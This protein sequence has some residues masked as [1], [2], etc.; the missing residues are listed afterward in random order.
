MDFIGGYSLGNNGAYACDRRTRGGRRST[1]KIESWH[2]AATPQMWGRL[3]TCGRLAIGLP[4]LSRNQQQADFQSAA[5]YHPAPQTKVWNWLEKIV[6]S[7]KDS[8]V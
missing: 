2:S 3:V 5:G 1:A 7:R 8:K 6:A 4:K